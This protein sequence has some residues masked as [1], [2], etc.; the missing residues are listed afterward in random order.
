MTLVIVLLER[1]GKDGARWLGTLK[2]SSANT[3]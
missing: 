2:A 3:I 1:G